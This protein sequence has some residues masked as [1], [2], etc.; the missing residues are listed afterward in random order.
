MP[1]AANLNTGK[2]LSRA[3]ATPT[4]LQLEAAECGAAALAMVLA[5]H[6][7]WVPLAELRIACGVSRDG[8]SAGNIVRAARTYGMDARGGRYDIAR[9]KTMSMPMIAFVNMNHFVVLEGFARGAVLL[10][11]P[12]FGRRKLSEAEFGR[13]YSGIVLTFAPTRSFEPGGIRPPTLRRLFSRLRGGGDAALYAIVSGLSLV[14]IGVVIPSFTQV[15]VDYYLIDGQDW[16]KWL[17]AFM[18]GTALVQAL[19]TFLNGTILQ[20]LKTR[21]AVQTAGHFVWRLLRLPMAFYAQ[22]YPG[23]IGSR[24][25]LAEELSDSAAGQLVELVVQ[26]GAVLFFLMVMAAYSLPLTG[27]VLVTVLLNLAVFLSTRQRLTDLQTRATIDQVKLGGKTMQ[28]LQMIETLKASGTDGVFFSQ[29]A[30]QHALVVN[31]QQ[32]IGRFHGLMMAIPEYLGQLSA[33]AVLAVGG[34]QVMDGALTI[35]LLVGFQMLATAFNSPVQ[36]LLAAGLKLQAARGLLDQ[37]DDVL[38][39][40]IAPEFASERTPARMDRRLRGAVS[41]TGITFG[42]SRL[43]PALVESLDLS[44]VPGAR[45]GLV[46]ASGSGKSTV[47]RLVAG[48]HEPWEGCIRFDGRPFQEIS[49]ADLRDGLCTVDQDIALF[50]GTVRDNITLWDQTMPETRVIAAARDAMIHDDITRRP[51]GYDSLVA[52]GGRNFSGGQ[53]Q[54]IEIA[55]ALV[56]D[57][58]VLI[59]DEATS[60]LDPVLEKAIMDNIRRRGCTCLIIAHRLSTIRDC[61]EILV[62]ERGRIVERG[63][64]EQLMA[65]GGI[66]HRL[67]ET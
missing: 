44:V 31:Q 5:S 35:G 46:G 2:R 40:D 11:D 7:R 43:K 8:S 55:R 67:V 58:A 60:A 15:F 39:Q 17:L 56:S 62:M 20:R 48:L 49:R 13:Q 66:Y 27:V 53:R 22:R 54:R 16:V 12:A 29:W 65:E 45:I 1:G 21:I 9:L 34:W 57:P 59:L 50:A 52:E 14:L 47:G 64:H 41:L 33:V 6:G 28:G 61:D 3:V 23:S 10:N 51:G 26:V 25:Q 18:V 42:Y 38:D 63:T 24:V 37:F 36:G 32:E 4:V 19:L 30:G